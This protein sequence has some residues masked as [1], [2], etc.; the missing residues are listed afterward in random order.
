[1]E[2]EK[3]KPHVP[4]VYNFKGSNNI[5]YSSSIVSDVADEVV[6]EIQREVDKNTKTVSIEDIQ[7]NDLRA[8][9]ALMYNTFSKRASGM[10][11]FL[12]MKNENTHVCFYLLKGLPSFKFSLIDKSIVSLV[13]KWSKPGN[14][15]R[16]WFDTSFN[17][18][19]NNEPMERCS[20]DC[21]VE[22]PAND[23]YVYNWGFEILS[24]NGISLH[25][26]L[27]YKLTNPKTCMNAK[28][29]WKIPFTLPSYNE[30]DLFTP[31]AKWTKK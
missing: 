6:K 14:T 21:R 23:I 30:V 9:L 2:E 26:V 18:L 25:A 12:T 10:T 7:V 1:M 24:N 27:N 13:S 29:T 5:V 15:Y 28:E 11:Y 8:I 16:D 22:I 31:I 20:T 3:L 19:D 4:N 17:Q